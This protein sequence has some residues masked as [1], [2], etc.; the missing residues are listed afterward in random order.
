MKTIENHMGEIK[1][2]SLPTGQPFFS[3]NIFNID[4]KHTERKTTE[5]IAK[6]LIESDDFMKHEVTPQEVEI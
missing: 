2:D 1:T 5:R 3:I 4:I 6:A